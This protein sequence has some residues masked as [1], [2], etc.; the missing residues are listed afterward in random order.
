M[1]VDEINATKM[2]VVSLLLLHVD[3]LVF[4]R[5][6]FVMSVIR[7]SPLPSFIP[8]NLVME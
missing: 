8:V 4:M 7:I 5:I 2:N 3:L 1:F 6:L